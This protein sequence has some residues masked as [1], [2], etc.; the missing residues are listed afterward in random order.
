MPE[1]KNITPMLPT[2]GDVGG[3][4][5]FY[6]KLGFNVSYRD[7]DSMAIIRR[8]GA[9]FMLTDFNDKHVADNTALRIQ[10]TDIDAL[11]AEYQGVE[12]AIHP[13][14]ALQ[15]KPWGTREFAI[16][17]PAGVCITFY[18]DQGSR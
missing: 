14:G 2:G 8:D 1:L 11:Y 10:V 15:D 13:N 3:A 4:V 17:D 18:E 16:L 5:A 12:G 6:E 7:G 9:E